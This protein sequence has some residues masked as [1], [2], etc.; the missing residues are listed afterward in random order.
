[1]PVVA[2]QASPKLQDPWLQQVASQ[3]TPRQTT[4]T[5]PSRVL[6]TPIVEW[7]DMPKNGK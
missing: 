1:M 4:A 3:A 2:R 7:F 5:G 6:L